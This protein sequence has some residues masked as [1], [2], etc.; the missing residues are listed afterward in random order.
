MSS[1]DRFNFVKLAEP[2]KDA[3]Y[4]NLGF[5]QKL[6]LRGVAELFSE[7]PLHRFLMT[8]RFSKVAVWKERREPIRTRNEFRVS[9]AG[10]SE[11]L[12]V[13][14]GNGKRTTV[15]DLHRPGMCH[16]ATK[17]IRGEPERID[18]LNRLTKGLPQHQVYFMYNGYRDLGG[19]LAR[20]LLGL[21]SG[22]FLVLHWDSDAAA[23]LPMLKAERLLTRQPNIFHLVSGTCI[24]TAQPSY[25]DMFEQLAHIPIICLTVRYENPGYWKMG[26]EVIAVILEAA[27]V[28]HRPIDCAG[29]YLRIR[30]VFRPEDDVQPDSCLPAR[31]TN[32][33]SSR[34]G[35]ND[36]VTIYRVTGEYS[37][38]TYYIFVAQNYGGRLGEFRGVQ[39][40]VERRDVTLWD[41]K[42]PVQNEN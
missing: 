24:P 20:S 29:R 25:A 4:R 28:K 3:I 31:L 16:V 17:R 2:Q 34:S 10:S 1:L 38:P 26:W 19:G 8:T 13:Q 12:M 27:I 6:Q 11:L 39:R 7:K 15:L 32:L 5:F 14:L 40:G 23:T 30:L 35:L 21:L 42:W 22:S 33:L 9:Q 41:Q 18:F 36:A 37:W